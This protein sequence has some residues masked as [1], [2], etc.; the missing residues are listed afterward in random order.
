[1]YLPNPDMIKSFPVIF[2]TLI[3]SLFSC[4][5]TR[6][7]YSPS[8][9]YDQH[10]LQQD[11]T[12][13]RNILEKK[14]PSLYWFTPKDSMNIYFEKYFS[15][16][17]DS[18]TEQQFAWKILAPLVSKIKCGHTSVSMS[19]DY[20]KWVENKKFASFPLFMKIWNDTMLVMANLNKA[21]S[22]V[23]KGTLIT[24]IN[25]LSTQVLIHKMFG[26]LPQDGDANSINYIRLSANFPYYHRN[27][28]GLSKTYQVNY[29]DSV[30][31]SGT[32]SIPLY[33][34]PKDSTAK[35]SNVK[36]IRPPLT[37]DQ[38]LR[39]HRSLEI[40]SSG[41]FAVI[42]LNTFSKG[43][44]RSF[45]RRS[46][47]ELRGKNI[48]ALILDI[49]Y[50]GGGR[51]GLSTLLTRYISR[52]PFKVADTLYAVTKN[53]RPYT[54]FI[55]GKFLNNIELFFIAQKKKDGNYHIA[56]LENKLFKPKKGSH[57]NGN[58]YVLTAGPTFSA[59]ALFCNA[60]KGQDNVKLL[61]EETGG[62]W[63]GNDGIMIPDITLPN[64]KVSVRLPL[65]RLVQY[66][67]ISEK[68]TG[69]IPDV[70]IGTSYDALIHGYDKK[71]RV[72]K[73]MILNQ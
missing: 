29:L 14:H 61:G 32:L 15:A 53:L 16:I 1:M 54:R 26:Y 7:N 69:V 70:Y 9:K 2:F 56:H 37:K 52:K 39:I 49:R 34:P 28:F 66:N 68:G 46:F 73:Q 23:K 44:L 71:M 59:A 18:M 48:N 27:I 8:K 47:K 31:N 40:D 65:F 43:R 67:H 35:K 25:G 19:K 12:L 42:T 10:S 41:K 21:D 60:I 11:Y 38:K 24:A 22:I 45:F 62:G 63:Y 58:L 33:S 50:N 55:S 17:S 3:V 72:A 20:S 30:G 64:T 57:Y 36:I 6:K 4:T 51:I 5:A 13:L